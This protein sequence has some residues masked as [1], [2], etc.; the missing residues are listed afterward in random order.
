M[1][2]SGITRSSLRGLMR[3]PYCMQNKDLGEAAWNIECDV[4]PPLRGIERG[5]LCDLASCDRL[6]PPRRSRWCS[7]MCMREWR[8]AYYSNHEWSWASGMAAKRDSH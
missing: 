8:E 6:R 3:R 7:D 1:A 2:A 5:R 4:S